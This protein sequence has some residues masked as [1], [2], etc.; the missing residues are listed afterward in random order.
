MDKKPVILTTLR[1]YLRRLQ[2]LERA[3]CDNG[4]APIADF[5]CLM[6]IIDETRDVIRLVVRRR[7]L[8][9]LRPSQRRRSNPGRTRRDRSLPECP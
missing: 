6:P 7:A 4:T 5:P 9:P 1:Q 2:A 8:T 3:H